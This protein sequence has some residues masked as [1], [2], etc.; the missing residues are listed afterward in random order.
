MELHLTPETE[1]KLNDLARR[2][3]RGADELLDEA[4]DHL[5]AYN[6][7]FERKVRDS[8]AAVSRGQ[9]VPDEEVRT[10]LEARERR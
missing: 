10:W 9:T 6:E 5:V 1:A 7:W 2:T 8:Q 4:V 3:R